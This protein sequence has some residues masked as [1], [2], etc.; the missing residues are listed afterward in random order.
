MTNVDKPDVKEGYSHEE[1]LASELVV[2]AI[3]V[4]TYESHACDPVVQ[5][6]IADARNEWRTE[7]G[8]D[9]AA[10]RLGSSD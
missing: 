6:M 9:P 8:V 7:Y 2:G 1:G 10:S 5:N 4:R 3:D